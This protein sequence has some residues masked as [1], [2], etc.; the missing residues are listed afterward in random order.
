MT[1]SG[2]ILIHFVID[3]SVMPFAI[4]SYFCVSHWIAL[5]RPLCC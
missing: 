4:I 5:P 2:S 1:I 3:F